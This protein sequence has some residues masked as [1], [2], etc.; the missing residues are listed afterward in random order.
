MAGYWDFGKMEK[1]QVLFA[2]TPCKR[3]AVV[4][5]KSTATKHKRD[6]NGEIH[7]TS[8]QLMRVKCTIPCMPVEGYVTEKDAKHGLLIVNGLRAGDNDHSTWFEFWAK[9]AVGR[10]EQK[11]GMPI[12]SESKFRDQIYVHHMTDLAGKT[13]CCRDAEVEGS[14]L[15][16]SGI[17]GK[18]VVA[19]LIKPI[20]IHGDVFEAINGP[21][22]VVEPAPIQEPVEPVETVA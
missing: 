16:S 6:A 13:I 17:H 9:R 15:S 1:G 22:T 2:K 18:E 14:R 21:A 19:E 20:A 4:D 10:V 12:I 7:T 5:G 11:N 8:I 3:F